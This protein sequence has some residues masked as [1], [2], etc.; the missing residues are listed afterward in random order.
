MGGWRLQDESRGCGAI[1]LTPAMTAE[2]FLHALPF[3]APILLL[4]GIPLLSRLLDSQHALLRLCVPAAVLLGIGMFLGLMI[5]TAGGAIHPPL[6]KAGLPLACDGAADFTS[7][8]Y[9]Y[10][11]GQHGV[12]R[13][14]N[15][16]H[17]DGSSEE[18]TGTVVLTSTL[19]YGGAL[20]LLLWLWRLPRTWARVRHAG[21][22]APAA[23]KR[24]ADIAARVEGLRQRLH[25]GSSSAHTVVT[26]NGQPVDADVS[27]DVSKLL[28]DLA[29]AA[30]GAFAPAMR[31]FVHPASGQPLDLEAALRDLQRL[32][33]Q[34]L[35]TDQEYA[36]KKAELLA[37]L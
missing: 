35:I 16:T 31:G 23:P 13:H 5:A 10:K 29:A 4:L 34:R 30:P 18:I 11:P 32:F 37:R 3:I 9:S 2:Q 6:W 19:V 1:D 21:T 27:A 22:A 14:V 12:A 26:V 33:D 25:A 20:T 15:C 8:A 17:P 28:G 7:Q 24:A 36:D